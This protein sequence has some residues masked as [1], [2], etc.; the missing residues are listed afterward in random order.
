MLT[1]PILPHAL[2]AV[3]AKQ[4]PGSKSANHIDAKHCADFDSVFC[5][6]LLKQMRSTLEENGLFCGDKGDV[7]G[8]LFDTFLGQAISQAGGFGLASSLLASGQALVKHAAQG[9]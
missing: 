3:D 8:G 1:T 4:T 2:T 6:M 7:L 5:S 9:K